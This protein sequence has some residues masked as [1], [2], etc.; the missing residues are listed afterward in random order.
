MIITKGRSHQ[1]CAPSYCC[2]NRHACPVS[3]A[4][5]KNYRPPF[6]RDGSNHKGWRVSLCG[7]DYLA[8]FY[9]LHRCFERDFT[10]LIGRLHDGCHH[11]VEQVHLGQMEEVETSRITVGSGAVS[12]L[13]FH[14][15]FHQVL[16]IGAEITVLV[17]SSSGNQWLRYK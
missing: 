7:N 17:L 1:R 8:F 11:A 14:L 6:W 10:A 13:A 15:K 9:T 5:I 16:H 3:A 12:P 4:C 2:G